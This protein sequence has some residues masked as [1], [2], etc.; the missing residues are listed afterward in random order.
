MRCSADRHDWTDTVTC[1]PAE[2]ALARSGIEES[3]SRNPRA[4][5][6]SDRFAAIADAQTHSVCTTRNHGIRACVLANVRAVC[7]PCAEDTALVAL[8]IDKNEDQ[9][10]PRNSAPRIQLE[11]PATVLVAAAGSVSFDRVS[12]VGGQFRSGVQ[13]AKPHRRNTTSRDDE[14]FEIRRNVR[15]RH[16]CP[17]GDA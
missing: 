11:S 8:P 15:S 6:P 10:H 14:L 1:T 5:V 13:M 12:N 9:T 16:R 2:S 7:T 17:L 4:L 3:S